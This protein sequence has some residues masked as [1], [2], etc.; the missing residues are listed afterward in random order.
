MGSG[1]SF[2]LLAPLVVALIS[3]SPAHA[4]AAAGAAPNGTWLSQ[5]QIWFHSTRGSLGQVMAQIRR[6]Q[7][8]FVFLDYRRVSDAMQREVAQQARAHGLIPVVWVQS[9]STGAWASASWSMRP[10]MAMAS[11]WMTISSRTTACP[12]STAAAGLHQ[13]DLLQHP[14]L[15]GRHHA[16]GGLQPARC[17]VLHGQTFSSC[18]KLADRLGAVVSLSTAGTLGRRSSLGGRRFNTFLWPGLGD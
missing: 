17:A 11:R 16:A 6:E 7:Y 9:P 14:A 18:V 4:E 3:A 8:R 12:T 13:T 2:R 1:P 10:A 5:P 15:P